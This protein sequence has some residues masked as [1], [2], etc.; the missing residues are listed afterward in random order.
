MCQRDNHDFRTNFNHF[1]G[2]AINSKNLLWL[3]DLNI[4]RASCSLTA[5]W[6]NFNCEPTFLLA[7]RRDLC[8]NLF[9]FHLPKFQPVI[10]KKLN[11]STNS[12]GSSISWSPFWIFIDILPMLYGFK[13]SFM[14]IKYLL[15]YLCLWYFYLYFL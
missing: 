10:W 12:S 5:F 8:L 3:S 13:M 6:L 11:F 14:L 9:L 1:W 15:H 4:F 7:S 2:Y